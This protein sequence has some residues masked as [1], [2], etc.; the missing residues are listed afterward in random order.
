MMIIST[1][2]KPPKRSFDSLLTTLASLTLFDR[3]AECWGTQEHVDT[4]SKTNPVEHGCNLLIGQLHSHLSVSHILPWSRHSFS[5]LS[6]RHSHLHRELLNSCLEEQLVICSCKQPQEQEESSSSCTKEQVLW[7]VPDRSPQVDKRTGTWRTVLPVEIQLWAVLWHPP[8]QRLSSTCCG[9]IWVKLPFPGISSLTTFGSGLQWLADFNASV[10][11][12]FVHT[13][14]LEMLTSKAVI[15][16]TMV[17]KIESILI[18]K[19]VKDPNHQ[20]TPS[21]LASVSS[22]LSIKVSLTSKG[23]IMRLDTFHTIYNRFQLG[24]S[25]A[26]HRWIIITKFCI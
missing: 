19:T 9:V 25:S 15:K 8:P 4:W 10:I 20:S 26:L 7:Q 6:S 24:S 11:W 2:C 18:S 5:S 13:I 1:F 14:S 22:A 16:V 23:F 17:I 21:A 12:S 3:F